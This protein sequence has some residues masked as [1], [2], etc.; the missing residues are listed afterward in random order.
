MWVLASR[1][2]VEHEWAL[3]GE[4][5]VLGRPRPQPR[6]GGGRRGVPADTGLVVGTPW[7]RGMNQVL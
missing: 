4:R 6:A 1:A 2:D 3:H 7:M 5:V